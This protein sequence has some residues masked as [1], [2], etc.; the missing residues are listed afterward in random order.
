MIEFPFTLKKILQP[1]IEGDSV[2]KYT[3]VFYLNKKVAIWSSNVLP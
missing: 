2:F 3:T 1:Y